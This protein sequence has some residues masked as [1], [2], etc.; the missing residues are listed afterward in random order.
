MCNSV[1]FS[2]NRQINFDSGHD[3]SMV[4]AIV[5]ASYCKYQTYWNL[6]KSILHTSLGACECHFLTWCGSALWPCH[7]IEAIAQLLPTLFGKR[8]DTEGI[9]ITACIS[10]YTSRC[11]TICYNTQEGKI[12]T[13]L[14][15]G[16]QQAAQR[17]GLHTDRV[18]FL[19]NR[20]MHATSAGHRV[21]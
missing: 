18:C 1:E 8:T 10:A 16:S 7:T 2:L 19:L 5:S 13:C 21:K 20:H 11:P 17:S 15:L 6:P 12:C 4:R 9:D 14:A 3:K